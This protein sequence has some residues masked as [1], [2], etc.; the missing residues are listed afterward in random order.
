MACGRDGRQTFPV[1]SLVVMH[2][3]HLLLG[4]LSSNVISVQIRTI[5]QIQ[6]QKIALFGR[7][8][9]PHSNNARFWY[10]IHSIVTSLTTTIRIASVLY[11]KKE[12]SIFIVYLKSYIHNR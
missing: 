8:A 11:W 4:K 5:Q 12:F 9:F 6:L 7:H 10:G 1:W 3:S 2:I